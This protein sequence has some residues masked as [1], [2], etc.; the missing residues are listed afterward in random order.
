MNLYDDTDIDIP[1]RIAAAHQADLASFA[2]AGGW[3][4]GEERSAVVQHARNVRAGAGLQEEAV[5]GHLPDPGAVLPQPMLDLVGRLA[6]SPNKLEHSDL[7]RAIAGGISQAEYVEVVGLVARAVNLD[8][9][10]RGLGLAPRALVPPSADEPDCELPATAVEEGAWVATVPGGADGGA[11]GAELYGK[12]MMP[13]IYRALSLVPQEAAHIM[14]GGN[15]QYLTL[16]KFFDFAYSLYPGL[17]RA[18]VEL[19]A[20]R[21]SACNE[22]FY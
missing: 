15:A 7:D 19:V 9:F 14:S 8:I 10:A 1:G 5:G 11:A 4:T 12:N 3:L 18:Q 6:A 17:S 16:D 21:V 22:C 13:F 20:G 2:A